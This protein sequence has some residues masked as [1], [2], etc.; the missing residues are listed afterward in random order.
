MLATTGP[1]GTATAVRT[2][3]AAAR[4]PPTVIAALAT[5]RP[6]ASWSIRWWVIRGAADGT[7]SAITTRGSRSR[8]A[9]AMPL[10]ALAR[11]GPRV[12][13]TAPGVPVR[14][15]Q[16]AAMIVA[17]VSPRAR[18]KRSPAA[19]AAPTTSRLGPPPGTPNTSRVPAL[20][21]AAT[22][23]LAGSALVFNEAPL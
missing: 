4:G 18:T 12:T 6:R 7:V 2:A 8:A 9:C 10:T 11:P 17:A 5:D 1:G 14:S 22:I 20:A 19:A 13:T 3:C 23:A 16:V 15:A 21:S